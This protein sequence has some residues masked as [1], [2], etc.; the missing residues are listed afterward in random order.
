MSDL[1]RSGNAF[2]YS[3]AD[4]RKIVGEYLTTDIGRTELAVKYGISVSTVDSYRRRW[5]DDL[6]E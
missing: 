6:K 5:S 1:R 4:Q 3:E 2:K